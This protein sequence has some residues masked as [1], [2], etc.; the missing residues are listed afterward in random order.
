MD[1]KCVLHC[2]MYVSIFVCLCACASVLDIF[3]FLRIIGTHPN[4][5]KLGIG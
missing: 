5:V 3:L 2:T 4:F 1:A